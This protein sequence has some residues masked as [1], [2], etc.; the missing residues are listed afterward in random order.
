[1]S[2]RFKFLTGRNVTIALLVYTIIVTVLSLIK[3]DGLPDVPRLAHMDKLVHFCFYFGIS[4]LAALFVRVTSESTVQK[5]R[6]LFIAIIASLY[7]VIIE[8]VQIYVGRGFDVLDMS[9]NS[10]GA[11]SGSGAVYVY[12]VFRGLATD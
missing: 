2:S 7:G 8:V 3:V 5:R 10:V 11:I 4:F 12:G 1:M 9:A 6:F